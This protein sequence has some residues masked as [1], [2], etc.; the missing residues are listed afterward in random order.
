[1]D[2]LKKTETIGDRIKFLREEKSELRKITQADL[3]KVM[4]VDAKQ[5]SKWENDEVQLNAEKIVKLADFFGVSVDYL[6]RGGKVENLVM[7]NETGLTDQTIDR[8]RK[9]YQNGKTDY[10]DTINMLIGETADPD[11]ENCVFESKGETVLKLILQYVH[12]PENR[13]LAEK[14]DLNNPL[15]TITLD[16]I[17][18]IRLIN[19]LSYLRRTY[20]KKGKNDRDSE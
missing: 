5:I 7:I 17:Q 10:A 14:V 13:P 1:M 20:P 6:L 4:G 3:S 15:L 16:E 18:Q 19:S 9:H 12:C 8:L 2:D 11:D